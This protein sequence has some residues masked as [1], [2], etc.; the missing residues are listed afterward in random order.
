MLSEKEKG[1]AE[2]RM[3]ETEV[4]LIR[5]PEE[6]TWTFMPGKTYEALYEIPSSVILSPGIHV[7]IEATLGKERLRS[8]DVIVSGP[9]TGE[10]ERLVQEASVFIYL[11]NVKELLRVAEELIAFFPD[12]SSGYWFKG[13]ALESRENEE[14]ALAAYEQALKNFPLPGKEGNAEPPFRL[15]DKISKLR[16]SLEN[17]E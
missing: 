7:W 17:K 2:Y 4:Q 10:K 12:D 1:K 11:E 6:E 5:A 9:P 15:V 14:S 3:P 16:Q 13:M 8:N